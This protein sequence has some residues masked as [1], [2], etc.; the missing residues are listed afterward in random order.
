MKNP[1]LSNPRSGHESCASVSFYFV[2]YT[3]A[4]NRLIYLLSFLTIGDLHCSANSS[5]I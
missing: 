4:L 3:K 1:T 5:T 2:E